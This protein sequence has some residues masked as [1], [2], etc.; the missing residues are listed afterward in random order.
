MRVHEKEQ[1]FYFPLTQKPQFISFDCGNHYL[2]TVALEYAIP[3]LKAQ[4][5]SEPDPIS[6]IYAAEALGKKGGLESVK[7]LSAA[8]TKDPFWGV[9]AEVAKQLSKIKLD[10]AFD[11]LT[12]GLK[13]TDARVR[14]AVV[15]AL[16][17]IKTNASYKAL[18]PIVKSGDE[19]YYVEAAACRAVGE[20][21]AVATDKPKEEKVLKLLK[22]VLT[23]KAG[24]N[25]LVRSGAIAGLAALKTSEAALDIILEYTKLGVP[26]SL[27]LGSIRALGKISVGQSSPN[28]EKILGRLTELAKETFF[29]TQVAVVTALGAMETPKALGILQSLA[30][31]TAD[32]RVRRR[33]EE[34]I[35]QVQKNIGTEKTLRQLREELDQLKHLNQKLQS[36][37][38]NLEALS[39]KE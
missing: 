26:Q 36:R 30:S 29:L 31:Q 1:S 6:R 19:S 35:A 11:G 17:T 23:E 4:L 2:K 5:T 28:L 32:G 21:A 15:E 3:E 12:P 34:Q 33:A 25:E 27:R 14:R 8:L 7:A 39:K 20:I 10:Q 13:D 16:A 38:E 22:T 24:W 9:R 18:K 37:L